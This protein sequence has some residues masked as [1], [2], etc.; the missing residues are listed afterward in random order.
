MIGLPIIRDIHETEISF[1]EE[2]LYE[3]IFIPEGSEKL[4]KEIIKHPELSRYI[5]EFGKIGDICLVAELQ[6]KLIGAIWTR[7]Y[8]E[9]E[10]GYGF[11]NTETPEL[12]MA[13][14]EQYRHR[15]IGTLLL[16][17]MIRKLIEHNYKQVS[18]SVDK[19]NYAFD[20]YKEHGFEIFESTKKSATMIKRMIKNNDGS[21]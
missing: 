7:I 15:G 2:M 12:S 9:N 10:K 14:F 8:T 11:V 17:E 3:A 21:A 20:F 18:L 5:K 4:P 1:L 6:G 13:I 19:Q 16:K